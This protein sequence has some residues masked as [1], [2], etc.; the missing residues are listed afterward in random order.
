MYN[1]QRVCQRAL[2]QQ[3]TKSCA[4]VP[5]IL[6]F[7]EKTKIWLN[8]YPIWHYRIIAALLCPLHPALHPLTPLWL[9]NLTESCVMTLSNSEAVMRAFDSLGRSPRVFKRRHRKKELN[10]NVQN[11]EW[12]IIFCPRTDKYSVMPLH[13][14]SC[15]KGSI[16]KSLRK[17]KAYVNAISAWRIGRGRLA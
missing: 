17:I 6:L 13:P 8:L 2:I 12:S 1:D 9:P 16:I 15:V 10:N 14:I 11:N 3:Q 4:P 7:V 5:G